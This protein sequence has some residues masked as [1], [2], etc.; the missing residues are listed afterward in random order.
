MNGKPIWAKEFNGPVKYMSPIMDVDDDGIKDYFICY[1]S[2]APHWSSE[3]EESICYP[4]KYS[5]QIIS[6]G[7]GESISILTGDGKNFTNLELIFLIHLNNL[8]DNQEDIIC[9][10]RWNLQNIG[11]VFNI[12]SYY[13]NGTKKY[14]VSFQNAFEPSDPNFIKAIELFP[15]I[16]RPHLLIIGN[17]S[18]ALQDITSINYS[19]TIYQS[20]SVLDI[21]SFSII[22]DLNGNQIPEFIIST[23]DGKLRLINGVN[24]NILKEV[25]LLLAA[26]ESVIKISDFSN[27]EGDGSVGIIIDIAIE[28]FSLESR[29]F[30][31][32][33]INYDFIEL[34]SR[35]RET[36]TH[37][38]IHVLDDDLNNDGF[39]DL[40]LEERFTPFGSTQDTNRF[41]YVSGKDGNILGI[42]NMDIGPFS[43]ISIPDFD[44][45][46]KKDFVIGSWG[47]VIA[48]S[49]QSPI[50][51]WL[52]PDFS[53]GFPLFVVLAFLLI[54]GTAILII[55]GRKLHFDVRASIKKNKLTFIANIII[56]SLVTINF[57]LF[58][59]RI[60]IFNST[61]L[62]I[63]IPTFVS[64]SF[65]IEIIIWYG[66]LPLTAAIYNKFSPKFAY[67]L[68][69]I[70]KMFFKISKSNVNEILILKMDDREELGTLNTL[71]R[72]I[73]PLLL[74][75]SIGFLS[76]NI[77]APVL[78]FPQS[79]IKFGSD[80]FLRF[81]G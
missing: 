13:V 7:S 69:K 42:V 33:L 15:H 44:D 28:D 77:L 20:S 76:Y 53:F 9:L 54:A 81:M 11:I 41:T 1:A 46:G 55:K 66:M 79:F 56:I 38:G 19:K 18:Y 5:N 10:H 34:W 2:V 29:V 35:T 25:D 75:I 62:A 61:L 68:I 30:T 47:K 43:I 58:L 59:S 40:I 71:R 4:N 80:E 6:G 14:E 3:T 48:L 21:N 64:I 73:I 57:L 16:N 23:F 45:N 60:N 37:Y 70:R 50:G 49:S 51:I 31:I 72:I 8:N 24:G 78:G 65:L 67:L 36:I 17:H 27:T 63:G 74:S 26:H 22:N 39:V 52:S 12:T 32:S